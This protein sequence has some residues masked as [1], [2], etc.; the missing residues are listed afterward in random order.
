MSDS[1]SDNPEDRIGIIIA[2]CLNDNGARFNIGTHV[3]VHGSLATCRRFG[4]QAEINRS[5][6]D[7][8][9]VSRQIALTQIVGIDVVV[10][11]F[12]DLVREPRIINGELCGEPRGIDQV[13]E[14]LVVLRENIATDR[15]PFACTFNG[16]SSNFVELNHRSIRTDKNIVL[17][18][19]ECIF[20]EQECMV[21]VDEDVA[22]NRD[23]GPIVVAVLWQACCDRIGRCVSSSVLA[24]VHEQI[25]FDVSICSVEI[26]PVITPTHKDVVEDL[27][28]RPGPFCAQEVDDVAAIVAVLEEIVLNNQVFVA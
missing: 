21:V 11:E 5:R 22:H 20:L 1:R 13:F 12:H 10:A 23:L 14:E 8:Q 28:H 16:R 25:A 24:E 17:N 18:C 6:I 15:S 9:W 3:K 19:R 4:P 27:Q 2:Y 7:K 26:Q